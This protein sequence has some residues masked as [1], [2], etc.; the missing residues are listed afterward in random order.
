IMK[1]QSVASNIDWTLI[2]LYII[3]V[4]L[5]W[6][7]I[8]SA[9]LP[10]EETSIFDVG[11][12]YGKQ[13]IFIIMCIPMIFVVLSLDAKI[14]DKYALIFYIAALILLAGLF[15]AGK[16]VKGQTNWYSFGPFGFQPSEFAKIAT[17]LMLSKYLSD[18]QI[19]LKNTNHQLLAFGIIALPVGLIMMQ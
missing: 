10:I 19:N 11:Q 9:S 16:T 17:A 15:V 2:L 18:V 5:G 3:L 13:M 12:I 8:Y 7:T 6:M 4:V 14:Y 1:N